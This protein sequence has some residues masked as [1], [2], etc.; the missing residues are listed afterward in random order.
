ML[1]AIVLASGNPPERAR[2]LAVR[3]LAWLVSA[4]VE[5]VVRDVTAAC[6]PAW[7]VDD[8]MDHAGCAL[9]QEEEERDRLASA[10]ALVKCDRV[11][12]LRFGFQPEGPLVAEIDAVQSRLTPS[13]PAL[14]LEAP[15]TALQRLMPN[16]APVVGLLLPREQLTSIGS[17]GALTRAAKSGLRLRTRLVPVL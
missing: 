12:V 5:G 13:T 10:A 11:L 4:V 16:R 7:P 17:F 3:S 14:L 6:P 15:S 2:E 8:V 9:V 1:S